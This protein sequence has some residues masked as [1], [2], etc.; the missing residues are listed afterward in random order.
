M[1]DYLL[2]VTKQLTCT[3]EAHMIY[4]LATVVVLLVAMHQE[5][6]HY[7]YVINDANSHIRQAT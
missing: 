5:F 3:Y 6:M 1:Y 7:V 4:I 2:E